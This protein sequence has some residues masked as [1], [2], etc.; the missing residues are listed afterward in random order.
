[1]ELIRYLPAL[2]Q[3]QLQFWLQFWLFKRLQLLGLQP[4]RLFQLPLLFL[5]FLLS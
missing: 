2:L 3:L 4:L 1:M 5:F